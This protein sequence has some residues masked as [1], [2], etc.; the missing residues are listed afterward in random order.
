MRG[1]PN[2][3]FNTAP[4]APPPYFPPSFT[5]WGSLPYGRPQ[6]RPPQFR[7]PYNGFNNGFNGGGVYG[8]GVY[9]GF[10]GF[11][12]GGFGGGFG[13]C[14]VVASTGSTTLVASTVTSTVASTV[15][16]VVNLRRLTKE[17]NRL[18]GLHSSLGLTLVTLV[19]AIIILAGILVL[20]RFHSGAMLIKRNCR[21][22]ATNS[23]LI[24]SAVVTQYVLIT[25]I[26]A[27]TTSPY[28][29]HP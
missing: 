17:K 19:M 5:L 14:T 18:L 21:S 6:L 29:L 7:P 10:N 22:P 16:D 24:S 8:G 26:A 15:L 13:G 12:G 23:H 28:V 25:T 4:Y 2:N 27:L 3:F 20:L 9:G 11:N 1:S